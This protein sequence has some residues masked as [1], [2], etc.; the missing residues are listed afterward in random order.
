MHTHKYIG[1]FFVHDNTWFHALRL[2]FYLST[3]IV[4][5]VINVCPRLLQNT[6]KYI[7]VCHEAYFNC[8][9]CYTREINPP[10]REISKMKY[11]HII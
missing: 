10:S 8:V 5:Y 6:K 4:Q 1:I 3:I 9:N 7:E 11:K 2:Q